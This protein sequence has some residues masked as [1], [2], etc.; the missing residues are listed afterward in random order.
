MSG[1]TSNSQAM[2]EILIQNERLLLIDDTLGW[3]K[4][5]QVAAEHK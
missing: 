5:R 2:N 4:A 3:E 1:E